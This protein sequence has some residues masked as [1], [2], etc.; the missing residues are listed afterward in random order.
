MSRNTYPH[1]TIKGVKKR[2]HRHIMEAHLGR[3]LEPNEHVYHLNGDS[4]DNRLENLVVIVKKQYSPR[5]F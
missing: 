2:L 1:K 4:K 5:S 3:E